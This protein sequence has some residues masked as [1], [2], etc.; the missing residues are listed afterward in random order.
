[1]ESTICSISTSLG[2]GAISIIRVTG[3]N[4]FSIVNNIFSKDILNIESHTI[5]YGFIKE[6]DVVIDEVLLMCMRAPKTYTCEDLI[7]INAHGGINVTRKILE[8]LIDNGCTLAE[9]GEFTKRAFL[10]GRIDLTKAE[11]VNDLINATSEKSRQ[12]AINDVGGRLSKRIQELRDEI[13]MILANIEVN[14]DYPEYKDELLVTESLMEE[15]LTKINNKLLKIIDDSKNARIIKDGI[16]IG[17]IGK[18]NVG[19]SSLLNAF[20]DEEKA[21]VTN[22]A[23]TTRDIVEGAITLNGFSINFIDTAGIRET[24]DIVEQIGV[25]KSREVLK[26][27]DVVILVLNSNEEISTEEK[28]I[29]NDTHSEKLIIFANKDDLTRKLIINDEIVYGNTVDSTGI[30]KLKERITEKLKI[31]EINV[32]NLYY[33]SNNRQLELIKKANTA[34]QNA[35]LGKS[36][37]MEVDLIEIDIKEAWECLGKLTGDFYEDELVDKI[38]SNFCLGK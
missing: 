9:E 12:M 16:N 35:L 29:I 25:N 34:I 4:T 23:G 11:A 10:N 21:I 22:I 26:K 3:P 37:M 8:L 17:I 28:E 14:I 15:Y 5:N 31:N 24:S 6:E 36:N 32:D 27:S 7:E 2:K 30:D 19:K 20:L 18:P 13:A 33:V 38:F 1:M